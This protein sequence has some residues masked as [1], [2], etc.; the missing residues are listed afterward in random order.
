MESRE[1]ARLKY[2]VLIRSSSLK[3]MTRAPSKWLI[4]DKTKAGVV[5][6]ISSDPHRALHVALQRNDDQ[7]LLRAFYC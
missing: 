5:C 7:H 4:Y 3:S 2:T 1:K 6:I